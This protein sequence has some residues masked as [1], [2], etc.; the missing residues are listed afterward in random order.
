[1]TYQIVPSNYHQRNLAE[2]VTHTWKDHFIG[3]M[4]GKVESFHAHLWFEAIPQA[5][6]QLILLQQSNVKPKISAKIRK[7]GAPLRCIAVKAF[8]KALYFSINTHE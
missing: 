5:E 4:S 3:V 6:R 2:K 1:M 7:E 8:S